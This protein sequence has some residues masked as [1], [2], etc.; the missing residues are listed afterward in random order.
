MPL[1]RKG[2]FRAEE[3]LAKWQIT[4]SDLACYAAQEQIRVSVV[5]TE[6]VRACTW[7][8]DEQHETWQTDELLCRPI[9]GIRDLYPHD[10]WAIYKYRWAKVRRFIPLEYEDQC[11]VIE[12]SE[13]FYVEPE[14]LILKAAEIDRFEVEQINDVSG[15]ASDPTLS[16]KGG[17]GSPTKHGWEGGLTALLAHVHVYGSSDIQADYVRV[18]E[19]WFAAQTGEP[20]DQRTIEKK[21]SHLFRQIDRMMAQSDSKVSTAI[22]AKK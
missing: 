9:S 21:V 16:I 17:R 1:P 4:E 3:M 7:T 2:L 13:G 20:P 10:V 18:M 11:K 8:S 6:G 19:D 22:R 12:P 14:D 5:V 15:S